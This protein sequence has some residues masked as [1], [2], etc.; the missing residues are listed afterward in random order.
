MTQFKQFSNITINFWINF[1]TRGN[2]N[3]V[4]S[5]DVLEITFPNDG[6]GFLFRVWDVVNAEFSVRSN[7]RYEKLRWH[8]VT[9][10]YDQTEL[11]GYVNAG[12]PSITTADG[13]DLYNGD[14]GFN[15][16]G[17]DGKMG[18][19]RIYDSAL[20]ETQIQ[21]LYDV[22]DKNGTLRSSKKTL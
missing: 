1:S 6:N 10:V 9:M 2:Y 13:N 3:I 20:T 7:Q 12:T 4:T 17:F 16:Q 18:E 5:P 21:S 15:I 22:I 8:M 11:R 14:A 19:F